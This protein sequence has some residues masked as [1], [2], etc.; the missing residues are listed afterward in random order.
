MHDNRFMQES[1]ADG[2]RAFKAGKLSR[3]GFL[4]LCALAG[5]VSS[6]VISGDAKAA[7]DQLVMWNWGGDAVQ[8]HGNAFGQPFTR[9]TGIPVKFDTSGP[10]EGKI[11][12]MVE[13]GHITADI[14]DADLFNAVSLG[15]DGYLEPIDYFVVD[16]QRTLP[17]YA[18]RY[19][20]SVILYGYAFVYDTKAFRKNPP[21]SWADFFNLRKFRGQ[22]AL[23]KW[24]NGS[25]EA[26]LMADGV[27]R[28][29]LYP[30]DME[31]ALDKIRSIKR[32][33]LYW[34]SASDAHSMVV[35][36]EV[37]MAMVWQN[38]GRGIEEDTDGRYK[39]VMNEA[40]A[41]PGAYIVPKGN[42]A[43]REAV[44]QFIASAQDPDAQLELFQCLGMTP[45]NPEAFYRIPVA[46][47][48][49]AI[50]SPIN[51]NRVA[52][53]DPEWWGKNGGGAVNAFL[54]AIS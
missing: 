2:L 27:P 51:I 7:A 41:M 24:A 13:S 22:R 37:S 3:R 8:C 54:E 32:K 10:L 35:N 19:G 14:C 9:T 42:P 31:R 43:G 17:Q 33:S 1:L 48:Q 53:N 6:A 45:A 46:L 20:I 36:N 25:L 12:E 34:G 23:Y 16:K 15:P 5:V 18:K 50:T 52:Y 38:R 29:Q 44:M 26:A 28:D 47:Q 49:Y 39:L 21:N 4:T 11:R 40:L 30:L